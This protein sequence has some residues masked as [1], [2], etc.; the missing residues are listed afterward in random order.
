MCVQ[1]NLPDKNVHDGKLIL[2]ELA[3][4]V[5]NHSE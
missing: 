2:T 3:S 5:P 1:Y 4:C